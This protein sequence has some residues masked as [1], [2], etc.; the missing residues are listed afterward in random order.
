MEYLNKG[1][2][3]GLIAQVTSNCP[4]IIFHVPSYISQDNT[5]DDSDNDA[6]IYKFLYKSFI[7]FFVE[8]DKIEE[9]IN[10]L[11]EQVISFAAEN[12]L[13]PEYFG[14]CPLDYVNKAEFYTFHINQLARL[15]AL[16]QEP[17]STEKPCLVPKRLWSNVYSPFMYMNRSIEGL[18]MNDDLYQHF[19]A[20]VCRVVDHCMKDYILKVLKN[21]ITEDSDEGSKKKILLEYFDWKINQELQSRTAQIGDCS[22][23]FVI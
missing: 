5:Q 4:S 14:F 1:G 3:V 22:G 20:L 9:R 10:A 21:L 17:S 8:F 6:K 13:S 16:V 7:Q 18:E 19:E 15:C 12:G 11:L 23:F 2:E